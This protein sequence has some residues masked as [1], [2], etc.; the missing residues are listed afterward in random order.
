MKKYFADRGGENHGGELHWPGT[1]GGFPFRG[2]VPDLKADELDNL[3]LVLDFHS[4]RFCVWNAQE[5]AEFNAVMDRITNGLYMQHKRFD[6]WSDEHGGFIIWLEW[7][8]I[9]G[10]QPQPKEQLGA[11]HAQPFRQFSQFGQGGNA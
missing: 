9:Y 5:H 6:R 1:P 3:P 8:Q 10:E 2:P 4:Q 11:N 7:V